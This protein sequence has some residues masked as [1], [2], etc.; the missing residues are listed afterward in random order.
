MDGKRNEETNTMDKV[1]PGEI[2]KQK[3][4]HSLGSQAITSVFDNTN[5]FFPPS[6]CVASSYFLLFIIVSAVLLGTDAADIFT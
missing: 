1:P 3:E 4:S 2:W 5:P 6:L